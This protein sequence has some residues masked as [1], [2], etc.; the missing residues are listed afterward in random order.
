MC[1][2]SGIFQMYCLP[3]MDLVFSHGSPAEGPRTL[4]NSAGP[5][6]EPDAGLEQPAVVEMRLESFPAPGGSGFPPAE[7]PHLLAILS[8]GS[9][10][11]YRAARRPVTCHLRR[12]RC[13]SSCVCIIASNATGVPW[14]RLASVTIVCVRR[15][16]KGYTWDASCH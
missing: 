8:D 11:L 14:E 1:S 2:K 15:E 13:L 6:A 9:M 7:R 12:L 10:L 3:A 4:E 5:A 16:V